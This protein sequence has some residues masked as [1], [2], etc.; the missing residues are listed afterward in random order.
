[1][2][3]KIREYQHI[4]EGTLREGKIRNEDG[5]T[6]T[7]ATL[8]GEH[9]SHSVDKLNQPRRHQVQFLDQ[10]KLLLHTSGKPEIEKARI[11]TGLMLLELT[12][13]ADSYGEN[14]FDAIA[15][16]LKAGKETDKSKSY[17]RSTYFRCL[18]VNIGLKPENSLDYEDWLLLMS[19]ANYFISSYVYVEGKSLNGFKRNHEFSAIQELNIP[20]YLH[21]CTTVRAEAEQRII[22]RNE[23]KQAQELRKEADELS[24][25]SG[26]TSWWGG[27]TLWSA[28]AVSSANEQQEHKPSSFLPSQ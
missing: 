2:V 13:I 7:R 24:E 15:K 11:M 4:M 5:F 3:F 9:H 8:R 27:L 20:A 28:P 16:D 6:D 10:S 26:N 18:M 1:M 23:L 19:K 25:K 17:Q 21:R 14:I 22:V 12:I